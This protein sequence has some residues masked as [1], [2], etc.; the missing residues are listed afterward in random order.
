MEPDE[1]RRKNN[2]ARRKKKVDAGVVRLREWCAQIGVDQDAAE[3]A[4]REAVAAG[5]LRGRYEKCV[6]AAAMYVGSRRV[7]DGTTI[8]KV[9]DT[10]G[11]R[12]VNV[13]RL[14]MLMHDKFGFPP[15]DLKQYV[16]AGAKKLNLKLDYT[17][18]DLDRLNHSLSVPTR[19]GIA[20]RVMSCLAG[21]PRTVEQVSSAVGLNPKSM[22][23]YVTVKGSLKS[24]ALEQ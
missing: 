12:Q 22:R 18:L 20:L 23:H 9:A 6:Q 24:R 19:A 13:R 10:T 1:R 2:A 17:L 3:A 15:Q 14:I 7:G 16:E 8:L 11:E 4:Y 21:T 5:F